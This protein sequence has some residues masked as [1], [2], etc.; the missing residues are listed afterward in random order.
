MNKAA[1]FDRDGTINV[2]VHYLYRC[3]DFQFIKGI[4]QFIKKFNDKRILKLQTL[5]RRYSGRG[6]AT[7]CG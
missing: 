1:F 7:P 5:Q 6:K 4:P 3:E 2:D